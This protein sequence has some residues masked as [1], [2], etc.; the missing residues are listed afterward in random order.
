MTGNSLFTAAFIG[1]AVL[2]KEIFFSSLCWC[3][4]NDGFT[5]SLCQAGCKSEDAKY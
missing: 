5:H 1:S 2:A 3:F 4:F